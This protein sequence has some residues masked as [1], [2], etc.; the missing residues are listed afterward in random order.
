MA[1]ELAIRNARVVDRDPPAPD[2]SAE[3]KGETADDGANEEG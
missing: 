3:S 2:G 1:R